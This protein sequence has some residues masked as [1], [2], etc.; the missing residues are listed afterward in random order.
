MITDFMG[1]ELKPGDLIA[2][3][4]RSG[5]NLWMTT[6]RIVEVI[7]QKSENLVKA[8]KE[9]GFIVTLSRVDNVIKVE[10]PSNG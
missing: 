1:K 6:A 3:P 4:C 9:S 7:E 5:S 8:R 10:G 2:Y